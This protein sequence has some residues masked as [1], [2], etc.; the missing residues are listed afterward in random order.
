LSLPHN[1]T[2]VGS[3]RRTCQDSGISRRFL[4]ASTG[5][6]ETKKPIERFDR[7][8]LKFGSTESVPF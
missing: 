5:V 2:P 7:F 3:R 8:S 4:A 6:W 1:K